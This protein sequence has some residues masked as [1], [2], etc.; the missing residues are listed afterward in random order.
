MWGTY[1]VPKSESQVKM[2]YRDLDSSVFSSNEDLILDLLSKH[3]DVPVWDIKFTQY[4]RRF[5]EKKSEL[6][7]TTLFSYFIL[8]IDF[9]TKGNKEVQAK[10]KTDKKKK[11]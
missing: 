11:K 4:G 10:L 9:Y 5:L 8:R 3:L 1:I 2:I 7:V 6:E